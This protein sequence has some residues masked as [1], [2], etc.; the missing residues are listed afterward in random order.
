MSKLTKN[1][2]EELMWEVIHEDKECPDDSKYVHTGFGNYK[3]KSSDGSAKKDYPT[4]VRADNCEYMI[5]G[6][7]RWMQ[8]TKQVKD[9]DKKPKKKGIIKKTKDWWSDVTDFYK[10]NQKIKKQQ[11]KDRITKLKNL[12]GKDK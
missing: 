6:G 10:T 8:Y 3:P 2:L 5:A 12:F 9:K 1:K 11:K 7:K 4:Y